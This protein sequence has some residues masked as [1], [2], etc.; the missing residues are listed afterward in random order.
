LSI[1]VG[2]VVLGR[3]LLYTFKVEGFT[4][5]RK[6]IGLLNDGPRNPWD[7]AQNNRPP[8]DKKNDRLRPGIDI[9]DALD[10]V[11]KRFK[12]SFGGGGGGFKG[13]KGAPQKIMAG[14]LVIFLGVWLS[15]GFYFVQEGDEAVVLRFGRLVRMGQPGLNFH[16]PAPVEQH[17]VKSVS[18]QNTI[19]GTIHGKGSGDSEESLI[20]T[21]DE[22]V[23]HTNFTVFWNIKDLP[24]YLFAARTPDTTIK[25]ATESVLRE[26]IGQM[27]ARDALTKKREEIGAQTRDLVQKLM[28]QYKLGVN[29]INVQLQRVA[30][31]SEV[32]ASFSDLQASLT[33]AERAQAEAEG[34]RNDILPRARGQAVQIKQEAEGYRNSKIAQAEGEAS[35]FEQVLAS[36]N[37]NRAVAIKRFFFETMQRNLSKAKTYIFDPKAAQGV[38][39]YLPVNE[40]AKS[41]KAEGGS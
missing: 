14:I 28:D 1:G 12:Q 19:D 18:A 39:P 26:I 16:F 29:I 15:T 22:N 7:D 3:Q 32:V 20:L 33:D 40:V 17:I 11:R 6:M 41:K 36:Y 35:R 4:Q 5:D 8:P 2:D 9:D 38:L 23:V 27:N 21:G 34:Y 13:Y 25:I 10:Q 31:P 30:P 24:A 37:K